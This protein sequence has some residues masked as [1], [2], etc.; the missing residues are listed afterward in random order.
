MDN[1]NTKNIHHHCPYCNEYNPVTDNESLIGYGKV[2]RECSKCK[3]LYA[4]DELKELA[5]NGIQKNDKRLIKGSRFGDV[6]FGIVFFLLFLLF[7]IPSESEYIGIGVR[8][9][10]RGCAEF[11]IAPVFCILGVLFVASGIWLMISDIRSYKK[12][13]KLLDDELVL[14]EARMSNPEYVELLKKLRTNNK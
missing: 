4:D 13:R 11:F 6:V 12:R 7:R 8:K 5:V 10:P 9:I 2:V 14:S 1:Q 3:R